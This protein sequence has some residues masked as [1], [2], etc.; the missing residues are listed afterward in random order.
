ML[1][2]RQLRGGCFGE[3]GDAVNGRQAGT[4]LQ[5]GRETSRRT[6]RAEC[7]GQPGRRVQTVRPGGVRTDDDRRRFARP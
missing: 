1:D 4:A 3:V 2:A 7:L 5:P 6:V